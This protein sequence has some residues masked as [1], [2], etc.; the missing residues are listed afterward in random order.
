MADYTNEDRLTVQIVDERLY[1]H[2]TLRVNYTTYDIRRSQDTINP[3]TQRSDVMVLSQDMEEPASHPYWYA[4][5]LGLFH[6]DVRHRGPLSRTGTNLKRMEFAWVR[7]YGVDP[8]H[9]SGPGSKRLHRVGFVS[10]DEAFGF[11]DPLQIV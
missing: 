1:M 3:R 5:V 9:H 6:V 7:W 2:K 4:K 8:S 11:I 10:G